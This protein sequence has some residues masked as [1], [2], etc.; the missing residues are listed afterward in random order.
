LE[1]EEGDKPL[2]L[3]DLIAEE[4]I[5]PRLQGSTRDEVIADLVD[6]L[7]AD[8]SI[9]P[10]RR[11]FALEAILKRE[12]SQTTG[13]GSGVA[14]PHGVCEGL[15]DVTG[16]LGVHREGVDFQ[17]VDGEPVHLVF[18]L[19]MPPNMFQAHIRTLAGVARLL[20]EPGLRREIVSADRA[21]SIMEILLSREEQAA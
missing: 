19:V 1:V 12:A 8:G 20:N 14:I 21:E 4:C 15:L 16:A 7:V 3:V 17:S 18:L 9:P 5:C 10:E 6:L 2:R 11:D 13:L